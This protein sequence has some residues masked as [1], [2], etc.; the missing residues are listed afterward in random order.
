MPGFVRGAARAL[1]LVTTFGVS[2]VERARPERP[3]DRGAV[4]KQVPLK[5]VYSTSYQE[6]LKRVDQGVGDK[7][8]PNEMAELYQQAIQL[9]ASNVFLARGEDVAA[10]VKAT[11]EV[12]TGGIPAD[13]PVSPDR[14]PKSG[15]MWLVAYLGVTGSD[16][17]AFR[18]HSV[19]VSGTEIR[20][21][22]KHPGSVTQDLH[23]YFY[24]VPLG[25]LAP[26]TYK[27]QLFDADQKEVTLMRRVRVTGK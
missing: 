17:T 19:E 23:P 10:A 27:L 25:K 26:G 6:G 9:G 5:S 16:P 8:F 1:L 11:W 22:Y 7:A 18:V 12:F 13:T 24:W 20:L 14:P 15:D 4:V 3:E 21:T 2:G